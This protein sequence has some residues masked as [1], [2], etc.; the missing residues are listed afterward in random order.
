MSQQ[1][2]TPC[3]S[4]PIKPSTSLAPISVRAISSGTA[5]PSALWGV[6]SHTKAPSPS[7]SKSAIALPKTLEARRSLSDSSGRSQPSFFLR[8]RVRGFI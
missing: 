1:E 7:P 2:K 4:R 6:E 3:S 8:S 5:P